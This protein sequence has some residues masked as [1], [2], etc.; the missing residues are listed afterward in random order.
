MFGCNSGVKMS[1]VVLV[2]YLCICC[3]CRTTLAVK[4]RKAKSWLQNNLA[5]DN[6]YV[7]PVTGI[8][9][10]FLK[11]AEPTKEDEEEEEDDFYY[12]GNGN[13]EVRYSAKLVDGT[14]ITPETE[15]TLN[16]DTMIMGLWE[17]LMAM[18]E[19]DIWEVFL[20]GKYAGKDVKVPKGEA[21]IYTLELIKITNDDDKKTLKEL[22]REFC[23]PQALRGCEEWELTYAKKLF[24]ECDHDYDCLLVEKNELKK[25]TGN[26]SKTELDPKNSQRLF[27]LEQLLKS[28]D[29]VDEL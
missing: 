9:V 19:G 21:L 12:T 10:N 5:K 28:S 1:V 11:V 24:L 6:V 25:W 3:C 4:S 14:I 16:S 20:P 22:E 29:A 17:S 7:F 23:D 18:K 2:Y 27:I 13:V 15:T 8:Q 26:L